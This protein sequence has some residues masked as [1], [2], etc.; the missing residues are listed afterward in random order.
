M[1]KTAGLI[2]LYFLSCNGKS[3]YC[4]DFMA[5][6]AGKF[7][8]KADIVE[9]CEDS[10]Y[11][12]NDQIRVLSS[13]MKNMNATLTI[14][15]TYSD[16]TLCAFS[17]PNVDLK[18]FNATELFEYYHFSSEL[19]SIMNSW[20]YIGYTRASDI[21]RI[22]LAHRYSKTYIDTDI[23]FLIEQKDLFMKPFVGSA[24]WNE[25]EAAIEITNS[26]FCL[27]KEIL[28][29]MI[30]FLK[31]R[32]EKRND[33]YFYTELGPSMFH[34]TLLN[35]HPVILQSQN[36]PE[37]YS[38]ANITAGIRLYNHS[39]LHL[40]GHIRVKATPL[41]YLQLVQGIRNEASLSPLAIP[42]STMAITE[43]DYFEASFGNLL[44]MPYDL[45]RWAETGQFY[46]NYL[47]SKGAISQ[48]NQQQ[49][50]EEEQDED[51]EWIEINR[52]LDRSEICFD[53]VIRLSSSGESLRDIQS[54]GTQQLALVRSLKTQMS[55]R[56]V[57]VEVDGEFRGE[58]EEEIGSLEDEEVDGIDLIEDEDSDNDESLTSRKKNSKKNSKKK[59]NGNRKKRKMNKTKKNRSSSSRSK[60]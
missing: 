10:F 17:Y 59:K 23:H 30:I 26:A 24:M 54:W 50:E 43:Y 38:V 22:L 46:V 12:A 36:H 20:N 35:K 42:Q 8:W 41:T 49:E 31:K 1:M 45:K 13:Q 32:I 19:L 4:N 60:K 57:E 3:L 40:T 2:G 14:Y 16:S 15:T 28:E 56:K 11:L 48:Q 33:N 44:L 52:V 47:I 34:K 9:P 53:Y 25:K 58:V 55:H 6:L 5:L 51:K 37:H 39:M 21:L 29:D 27:S 18:W 7:P